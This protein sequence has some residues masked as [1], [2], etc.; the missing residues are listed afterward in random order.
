M[1]LTRLIIGLSLALAAAPAAGEIAFVTN[2]NSDELSILDLDKGTE[3]ARLPVE[4]KPAGVAVGKGAEIYTVSPD[5]KTIRRF[6]SRSGEILAEAVLDG[7]PIGI[8]YDP[9][10]ERVFVSDWYNARIWVLEARSLTQIST[11][12]TG[13]APAGLEVFGSLLASADRDAHQ[14]S[15][16]DL[17][18]LTLRHQLDVGERPFGLGFAPDGRLFVGNVGSNDV[19]ILDPQQGEILATLPVGE[20]PYGV[21]FAKGQAFVTNQYE[22][23]VSVIDLDS[24]TV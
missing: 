10:S 18:D 2:Q 3:I 7:G 13:S 23:T 4:G 5:S 8:A 12:T 14:V 17:N 6:D 9:A 20:R 22:N 16:F 11:L 21:A 24:L 15:I 19:T 1:P